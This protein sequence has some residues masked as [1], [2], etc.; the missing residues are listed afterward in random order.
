MP[1]R[2]ARG[3]KEVPEAQE[4]LRANRASGAAFSGA[5]PT[6]EGVGRGGI[7]QRLG[8]IER[9]EAARPSQTLSLAAEWLEKVDLSHERPRQ[10]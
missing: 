7:G 8:E 4:N 9:F 3:S 5:S 10:T 1:Q 2:G 6:Q